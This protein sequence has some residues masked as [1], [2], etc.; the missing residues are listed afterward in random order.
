MI[1]TIH[2]AVFGTASRAAQS[3]KAT[4]KQAQYIVDPSQMIN[5]LDS[6]VGFAYT[7]N[8]ILNPQSSIKRV[9]API[10]VA[11]ISGGSTGYI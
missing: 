5:P 6:R 10:I 1:A 7:K 4:K 11:L 3:C 8:N 2:R 9:T